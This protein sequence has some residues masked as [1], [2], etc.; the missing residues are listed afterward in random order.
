MVFRST[1]D[2]T[3]N[4]KRQFFEQIKTVQNMFWLKVQ[5]QSYFWLILQKNLIPVKTYIQKCSCPLIVDLILK[6]NSCHWLSQYS[7]NTKNSASSFTIFNARQKTKFIKYLWTKNI[8]IKLELN[9]VWMAKWH[10]PND[11]LPYNW[12]SWFFF[13][14]LYLVARQSE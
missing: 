5:W 6:T 4:V 14:P 7:K 3:L 2:L 8:Q 1:Q 12:L 13:L 11:W 10:V 9:N